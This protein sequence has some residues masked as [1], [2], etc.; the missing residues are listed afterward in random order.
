METWFILAVFVAPI[1]FTLINFFDKFLIDKVA[2]PKSLFTFSGLFTLIIALIIF[3]YAQATGKFISISPKDISILLLSGFF[4]L[5]WVYFYMKALE[6]KDSEVSSVVPWFQFVGIFTFIFAF[7]LLGETLPVGKLMS[8]FM[9]IAG[10]AILSIDF[11]QKLRF[12]KESLYM[13]VASAIIALGY[14]LFKESTPSDFE[15]VTS[16]FWVQ[17]GMG[18]TAIL[19]LTFLKSFRE[20]FLGMMRRNGKTVF[21]V[22][23]LNETL[24]GIGVLAIGFALLFTEAVKVTALG[25]TQALYALLLGVIGAK[26]FPRYIQENHT[27]KNIIPKVLAIGLMVV[28]GFLLE[29]N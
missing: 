24:N 17:I 11:T 10:G 18:L 2:T 22:N 1:A 16:A 26:F 12:R 14:V 13:L 8:V 3:V 5:V 19:T 15:F 28:G 20:E 7:F 25:S 21:K 29:W 23:I 4:Q 6:V 27:M 9:I